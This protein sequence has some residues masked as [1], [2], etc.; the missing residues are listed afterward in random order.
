MTEA[1]LQLLWPSYYQLHNMYCLHKS[2]EVCTQFQERTAIH[3]LHL[4]QSTSVTVQTL[5]SHH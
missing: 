2:G 1:N 5:K 3:L 4:V